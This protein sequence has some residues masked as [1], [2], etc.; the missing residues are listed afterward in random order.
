LHPL[1][2]ADWIAKKLIL[3][4]DWPID[5]QVDVSGGGS[6]TIGN[7]RG[8]ADRGTM[9]RRKDKELKNK[10]ATPLYSHEDIREQYCINSKE[11]EALERARRGK[12]FFGCLSSHKVSDPWTIL[13]P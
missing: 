2:V 3:K 5:W 7:G 4:N 1:L 8:D 10:G 9:G 11:L 6:R 13:L 12:G